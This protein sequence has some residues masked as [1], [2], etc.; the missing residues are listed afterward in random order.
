MQP[1][2]CWIDTK[3]LKDVGLAGALDLP[4]KEASWA[5]ARSARRFW[6]IHMRDLLPVVGWRERWGGITAAWS[7]VPR[8]GTCA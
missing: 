6:R 2:P 1:L 5:T 8:C 3:T 4:L 7:C